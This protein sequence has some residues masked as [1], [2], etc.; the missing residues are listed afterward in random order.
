MLVKNNEEL[1]IAMSNLEED[2]TIV[3]KNTTETIR[4][5]KRPL[6][7]MYLIIKEDVEHKVFYLNIEIKCHKGKIIKFI[8][9]QA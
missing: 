1:A 9:G 3:I 4:I 8:R 5:E 6:V 2:E 7:N